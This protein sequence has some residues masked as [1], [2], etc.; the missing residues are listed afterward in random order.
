MASITQKISSFIQGISHQPDNMMT[1][2]QVRD[3]EN[4]LPDIT[5]GLIKRNGTT[6]ISSLDYVDLNGNTQYGNEGNWFSYYRDKTE[7]GYI[8]L[9]NQYGDIFVWSLN[10]ARQTVHNFD[11]SGYNATAQNLLTTRQYLTNNGNSVAEGLKFTTIND[12]TFVTNPKVKVKVDEGRDLSGVKPWKPTYYWTD[13]GLWSYG[14]QHDYVDRQTFPGIPV[15]PDAFRNISKNEYPHKKFVQL[16]QLRQGAEYGLKVLPH[17]ESTNLWGS[18]VVYSP[19][20]TNTATRVKIDVGLVGN[21]DGDCP[22]VGTGVYKFGATYVSANVNGP[23]KEE[24]IYARITQ[25][26]QSHI[27][28]SATSVNSGADYKCTYNYN[29]ELLYGGR[30]W[31]VGDVTHYVQGPSNVASADQTHYR[32]EIEETFADEKYTAATGGEYDL[33]VKS[34]PVSFEA[35]TPV[36]ANAIYGNLKNKLEARGFTCSLQGNGLVVWSYEPFDLDPID[37]SLIKVTGTN[38]SNIT[39]L[40]TE[41]PSEFPNWFVRI[42]NASER[43]VDDYYLRWDNTEKPGRW[44][45]TLGED[46]SYRIDPFTMPHVLWRQADGTF[47][48]DQYRGE[49]KDAIK[50]EYIGSSNVTDLTWSYDYTRGQSGWEHRKVGDDATNP[51]PSFI[52]KKITNTFFHRNR[53]GFLHGGSLSL[54]EA[55]KIGNF[56]NGSALTTVGNDPI[57]I[58]ASSTEPTTFIS[59]I[60]TNTG[61]VIFGEQEQYLLHTDSDSLTNDTAKLSNISTYNYSPATE[62][63]PLGTTISFVD[64]SGTNGRFFEMFGIKREGEPNI[65]EQTKIVQDLIPNDINI[66][67]NSRE[68]S[69]VFLSKEEQQYIWGYRYFNQGQKRIQSAWFKWKLAYAIRYL[70][71]IEGILYIVSTKGKLY[72]MNLDTNGYSITGGANNPWGQPGTL[73]VSLDCAETH[74]GSAVSHGTDTTTVFPRLH[75]YSTFGPN[76]ENV[77]SQPYAIGADGTIVQGTGNNSTDV[78]WTFPGVLQEPVTTGYAFELKVKFPKIFFTQQ[79]GDAFDTDIT[80]SLTVQRIKFHFGPVG[81]TSVDISRQGK[82]NYTIENNVTF[83]DWIESDGTPVITERIVETPIY[84]KNTNFDMELKSTYPGPA[85]LHSMSWEGEYST[86]HHKRV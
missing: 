82:P 17:P 13:T 16:K 28:P 46:I 56:F 86:K 18:Q 32:L 43:D 42:S 33:F 10:G 63:L 23:A 6:F 4:G 29:A 64:S 14:S 1:P 67:A 55:G 57:N 39:E 20:K 27:D 25:T 54:S 69:T 7:G 53:L 8:G 71:V 41:G 76:T 36:S 5:S 49:R 78:S 22:C 74:S 24:A 30:G 83:A 85:S 48:F 80:A 40:P 59:S 70:T 9:I 2:G 65:I 31:N 66:T 73:N 75:L 34:P 19:G 38:I 58:D 52:G 45:E 79:K 60:E 11:I 3:L 68:T 21:S 62:P 35:N 77:G 37:P 84:E 44:V 50:D 81:H 47:V 72:S 51:F 26:G 12:Y 15:D 61:L